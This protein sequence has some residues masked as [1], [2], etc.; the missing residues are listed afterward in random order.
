MVGGPPTTAIIKHVLPIWSTLMC[1]LLCCMLL[2][3]LLQEVVEVLLDVW[4]DEAGTYG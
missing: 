2:L 1:A 4:E 3:L